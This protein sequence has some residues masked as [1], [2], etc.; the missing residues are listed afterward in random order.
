LGGELGPKRL[1]LLHELVPMAKVATFV[2][3]TNPYTVTRRRRVFHAL[4]VGQGPVGNYSAKPAYLFSTRM[5]PSA[6]S[7][8]RR[9]L[10]NQLKHLAF[11]NVR[12]RRRLGL[13]WTLSEVEAE[14]GRR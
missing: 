1:E 7:G 9:S 2:N 4:Q 10:G 6:S 11:E 14:Q 8:C 13:V 3:P 5:S 12:E